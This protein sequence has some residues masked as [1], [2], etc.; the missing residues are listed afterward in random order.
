MKYSYQV[1]HNGIIDAEDKEDAQIK[2]REHIAK[3]CEE[4]K[5]GLVMVMPESQE[6]E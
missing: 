4:N 6:R 5:L 2:A 1:I 3:Y